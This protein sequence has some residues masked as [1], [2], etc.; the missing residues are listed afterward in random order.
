M[1]GLRLLD[2]DRLEPGADAW[3][4]IKTEQPIAVVKGDC[5]VIRS[6]QTTLGG[7]NIVELHAKRHRPPALPYPGAA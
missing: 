5:F 2:Q 1:A 4:Q 6:N 3:A 7:G